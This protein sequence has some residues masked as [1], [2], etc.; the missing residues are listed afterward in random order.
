MKR[1]LPFLALLI[2][3]ALYFIIPEKAENPTASIGDKNNPN[4][5][6]EYEFLVVR[7]P[8]TDAVPQDIR[9]REARLSAS[10]PNFRDYMLAKGSGA[11][12]LQWSEKGPGN[13][14]GRTRAFAAD[15]ENVGVLIAGAVDGGIWKS[16]NDGAS[17]AL[18]LRPEQTHST[19][20]I[21][22]DT[23]PGKTNNWYVGTGEF[24][25]STTNNTRWG[26]FYHGDGIYKSTNNGETWEILPSTL[27]GT[28]A[29]ADAFDFNWSIAVNP[30]NTA[31]DEVFAATWRGI[32]RTTNGGTSWTQVLASDNGTVNTA[33]VTT[34]VIVTPSGVMYAHTRVSGAVRIWRS[35]DGVNWNSIAPSNFPTASGRIV[36]AYAPSNDN[37]IYI[38][39]QSPNNT[40][41]TAGHQIWKYTD[42]GTG[43]GTWENRSAN[44]PSDL[45]TQTG[46]D[47]TIHVKPDN[48][49]FVII[50]GT[51]LYR[52]T[53]GFTTPN[54]I[55]DI[56]GYS[57]Y[58]EGNHHPDHQGGMFKPTNYNIY[59]SSSDGGVHRADN[60]NM[61]FPMQW[62]L[63]N[64]GYNVTQV[65]S[66]SISSDSGDTRIIAGAQDNGSIATDSSNIWYLIY[67]GDGTVVEL[68][69]VADDR[70][71]TQY[72]NGPMHR[73][74]RDG[75][76]VISINPSGGTRQ[77][78]VNPIALDPNNTRILYYGGGYSGSPSMITGLWRNDNIINAS[79]TDGW[80][81]LTATDF[82]SVTGW[83]R[84]V[85][86]IAVSKKNNAN[87]VY[88]GTTDG[89]MKRVD[90]ASTSPVATDIT[91]PGLN[92][93]TAQGGFV[94]GIAI[95]PLNSNRALVAFGN[96]NFQNL[97]LTTN[98]GTSWVDVEGNLSGP[99]GPSVRWATMIYSG[100]DLHVFIGTSIG[101]L[102]T[103][104]LQG[105]STVWVH[106][107]ANEIG[108]VLIAYMD[109]RESDRTLAVGTHGRGVFT[110]TYPLTPVDVK[111]EPAAPLA[112][113][114]HQNYPNPFNPAT[115]IRYTL[116]VKADVNISI[117]NAQGRQITTLFAGSRDA[118]THQHIWN[119]AGLPS[120]IYFY[121]LTAGT[122]SHTGKM[123]LLK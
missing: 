73:Q 34:D 10:L 114:L 91:P 71:Y 43:T 37:I 83:T 6:A 32:Y 16:T 22:Q 60:I 8:V 13:I 120:G 76:D 112:Y 93:G 118:G 80:S 30:A 20:C 48:P 36:F 100:S 40:P 54:N 1:I 29:I 50:G 17:W 58:P 81:R 108:N 117:Y 31:Q 2:L 111:P 42:N 88:V 89:L 87:V 107:A 92:G 49:D 12:Q 41:A 5:R 69:N 63:L 98:G 67:G 11:L 103:E 109:Y 27:S 26:S 23:R 94:R 3:A 7:D 64:N 123:V 110:T 44:L 119:A 28:P 102:M 75:N 56:G 47:M 39:V 15:V 55:T 21:A 72:Q 113:I 99:D 61:A 105:D 62:T 18:K 24:R 38:F 77:L 4:S 65:Y 121:K 115:T 46:Y 14:G 122:T 57:Y 51:N 45:S 79:A 86:T 68:G 106:A 96:Y 74:T 53:D 19:S 59:Y 35:T 104:R 97:W 52:S 9:R 25:G 90:S 78:F 70:M 85:S 116:P 101:L 33:T 66:V 84:R 95:D 82:G